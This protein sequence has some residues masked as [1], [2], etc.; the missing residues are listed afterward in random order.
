MAQD[1]GQE[2]LRQYFDDGN[3]SKRKNIVAIDAMGPL[4]GAVTLRYER[5]LGEHFS[6]EASGSKLIPL[7]IVEVPPLWFFANVTPTGGWGWSIAGH[8]FYDNKAP[9]RQYM[10]PR[11]GWRK[12]V[13]EDGRTTTVRDMTLNFGYNVFMGKH[14]MFCAQLGLGYRRIIRSPSQG[15]GYELKER[16]LAMPYQ[17]GFG[18]MF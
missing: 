14:F 3:L 2:D 12:F 7:Y 13:L 18:V 1:E 6:I 4:S 17:M 9:E 8:Y 11:Y 16:N 5:A 15:Y 10:G